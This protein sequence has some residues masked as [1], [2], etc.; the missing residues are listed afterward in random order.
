MRIVTTLILFAAIV[1]PVSAAPDQITTPTGVLPCKILEDADTLLVVETVPGDIVALR[2][3]NIITIT[4]GNDNDFYLMRGSHLEQKKSDERAIL[5]YL[6]VL[7]RDPDN[8]EAS[9]RIDSITQ[10]HKRK[11]WEE[12]MLTARQLLAEQEYRRALEAFQDVLAEN[13]DDDLAKQIVDQMCNTY[14]RIAYHYYNHCYDE[15]AIRQLA[16]AEE[17][18]PQSAEIYYVLGMIHHDNRQYELARQEYERALELDP[19]HVQARSRL[20]ALIE[21]QRSYGRLGRVF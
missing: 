10:R 7:K 17:L 3:S 20:L 19:T 18:N 13:P 2:K 12:G 1:L 4:E 15:G 8:E 9:E 6:Q 16:K 11:R 21:R 14:A 5:E